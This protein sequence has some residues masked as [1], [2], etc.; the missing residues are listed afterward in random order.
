[1][2]VSV[3]SNRCAIFSTAHTRDDFEY[4]EID[5]PWAYFE[6]ANMSNGDIESNYQKYFDQFATPYWH[7]TTFWKR[8]RPIRR[9]AG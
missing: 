2:P 8:A 5:E 9:K 1:M 3:W 7:S 6:F 4:K